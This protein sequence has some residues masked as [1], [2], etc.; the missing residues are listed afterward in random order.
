MKPALDYVPTGIARHRVVS[1]LTELFDDRIDR[2]E[3]PRQSFFSPV[4][5]SLDGATHL[6]FSA[7]ARD[8]SPLGIG[9]VHI[10]PLE[11]GEVIVTL[12]LPS[13]KTVKLRAEI[14]W[15]KDF[16]DGWYASGGRFLDVLTTG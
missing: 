10:M 14:V 9:L 7:F 11:K 5:L 12:R 1:A 15:C 16:G 6:Q 13:G 3:A 8:I 2:R 4:T